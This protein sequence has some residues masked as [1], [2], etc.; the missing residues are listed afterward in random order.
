MNLLHENRR[1]NDIIDVVN[2]N[3]NINKVMIEKDYWLMHSLWGLQQQGF[4][5][6][7]KG[8]TSLSKGYDAIYRFSE[9]I[10]ILIVPPE[11]LKV[12]TGKN[13]MKAAHIESRKR[14]FDWLIKN[15][16]IPGILEV[17]YDPLLRPDG[18]WRNG[19]IVL[20][21]PS[22]T[23]VHQKLKK[24]ILLEVG[25]DQVSPYN[26]CEI[27]SWVIDYAGRAGL[28]F[29]DNRALEVCCYNPEYTFV[30]KLSAISGK[31]RKQQETGVMDRN[32]LRH[33]YDIYMLLKRR[34]VQEFIGTNE[35]IEHKNKKFRQSDQEDLSINEAFSMNNEE[36]FKFYSQKYLENKTLHYGEIPSFK[37]IMDVIRKYSAQL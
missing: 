22:T 15:I 37:D 33:Y 7:L 29:V 35:Y 11:N 19:D 23:G 13:H 24:G 4:D 18:K 31:F 9:D 1:F 34:D 21:Y 5:F 36:T 20:N 14:Y 8:G 25:F 30:E 26:K 6:Y 27:S 32:F 2:K 28:D 3:E 12:Y 17:N 10:D 16:K